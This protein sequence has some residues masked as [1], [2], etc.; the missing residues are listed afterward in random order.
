[1]RMLRRND[2]RRKLVLIDL[3]ALD[4]ELLDEQAF[5]FGMSLNEFV[6]FLCVNSVCRYRSGREKNEIEKGEV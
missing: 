1:M 4:L 3:W 6:S 2:R 5:T